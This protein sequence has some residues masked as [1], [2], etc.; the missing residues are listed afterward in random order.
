MTH[1][2]RKGAVERRRGRS[3][4]A[5]GMTATITT[6]LLLA[7]ACA[8]PGC[9]LTGS[10][11]AWDLPP[12]PILEAPVVQPGS[13]HRSR[14]ESGLHR[15]L[16]EDRRLP[17]LVLSLAVRR[18]AGSE[19]RDRAGLAE[20]T[21]EL[22]K[23][24]AGERDAFELARSVDEIGASL[25]VTAGWDAVTVTV[26]GLSRDLDRLAE[27]L[28]DVA[29]RPRLADE[30]GRKARD[31]QLAGLEQ[32]RDDPGTL[33]RW[34]SAELLYPEHR[35]GLPISGTP[36]TVAKLDAAAARRFH[37]RL[38]APANA[39]L[40]ASGD[41]RPE[42]FERIARE[43]FGVERWPG[44]EV[45][46]PGPVPALPA[47]A[48]RHLRVIDRPDL[49]QARIVITHDGMRRDDPDRIA[50]DLMN[51]VLGGSGFSSRL[52]ARVR[53]EEGLAYGVGSFFAPRRRTGP[54]AVSTS[55]RVSEARRVLD[56][57]L[58]EL[59]AMRDSR[60]P[61]SGELAAAA[62]YNVGRF[63]L[64]L[65]TSAAVM[66]TLV[67]L[68]IYGLPEDSLD[69][70]R[71]RVRAATRDDLAAAARQRLHPERAAIVM[72]GPAESLVPLLEGLGEIEVVKP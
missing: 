68:D 36:E 22:M 64:S 39:I 1:P 34:H 69:T 56:L 57:L 19:E 70:Y 4:R 42:Q 51:N 62:S 54:F 21:A 8:A 65:E 17:R 38:F 11:K 53:S 55:T 14:E 9:F 28:A 10:R 72:V 3:R 37:R 61:S 13:L 50:I 44:A 32:G 24:G 59:R 67:S 26:T 7:G 58:E 41:L 18:G 25:R 15:L 71:T 45:P 35:Y 20:F 49:V 30:E 52:M 29:L 60:P 31:E 16:L 2:S 43:R 23:R 47:P 48:R 66:S 6:G 46:P 12:P 33:T 40:A 5:R 63:G 27:I